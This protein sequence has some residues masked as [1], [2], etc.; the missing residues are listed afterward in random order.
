[1]IDYEYYNRPMKTKSYTYEEYTDKVC[2]YDKNFIL[3][4]L[5]PKL[6]K[7]LYD[8]VEQLS[9]GNYIFFDFR[10]RTSLFLCLANRIWFSRFNNTK[11][12]GRYHVFADFVYDDSLLEFEFHGN[13]ENGCR[14]Y[15]V[16]M[17]FL[18]LFH[19]ETNES[20]QEKMLK[21]VPL[22][23]LYVFKKK[24]EYIGD[25]SDNYSMFNNPAKKS[26]GWYSIK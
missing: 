24:Y 20:I 6:L 22:I 9:K 15:S 21:I 4:E 8:V 13:I 23:D 17:S 3:L 19:C 5:Q 1:M 12:Y 25:Y 11:N 14:L 10:N 18:H 26:K 16:N 2:S 7:K